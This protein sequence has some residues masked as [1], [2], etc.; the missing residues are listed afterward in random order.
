[1]VAEK[2]GPTWVLHNMTPIEL[3][4]N[5]A[6][7]TFPNIG[8]SNYY[9]GNF[10]YWNCSSYSS[11][12]SSN[13]SAHVSFVH[14]ILVAIP[15][16]L[17]FSSCLFFGEVH[18]MEI[19][20]SDD[21]CALTQNSVFWQSR[22]PDIQGYWQQDQAIQVPGLIYLGLGTQAGADTSKSWISRLLAVGLGNLG[23]WACVFGL[24]YLGWGLP[25]RNLGVQG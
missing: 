18:H 8:S 3:G 10:M 22:N 16:N 13:V 2:I 14:S 15:H 6:W 20:M 4:I 23:T 12:L 9:L 11:M 25:P 24:G 19:C 1:M 7:S 5:K 21:T 17:C